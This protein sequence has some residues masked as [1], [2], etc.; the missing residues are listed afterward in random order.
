MSIMKTK[1][2]RYEIEGIEDIVPTLWSH[3]KVGADHQFYKCKEG[4]FVDLHLNDIEDIMLLDVQHKLF[5]LPTTILLTLLWLFTFPEIEFK[6]LYTLSHKPP[7]VIYEDLTKQKRVMR[8]DDLYKFSDETL[9]KVQDELHH[10]IHDF[11]LEYNKEMPRRKWTAIDR[12]MSELMVELI[13][14]QMRERMIIRNL[15]RLV[16]ARELEMDY[17]LM[18]LVSRAKVIENQESVGTPVGR[19]ILFR[20]IPITIPDTTPTVTLLT[21]YVDTTLTPTEIP[22]I[23]PI[24]PPSP[25][26]TPTSLDYSPASDT[27]FDPSEDPSS[28]HIPPLPATLPFISSTDD[29]SDSDTPVTPPSPNYADYLFFSISF[30]TLMI[31]RDFIGDSYLG[32]LLI[33]HLVNHLWDHSHQPD[34]TIGGSRVPLPLMYRYLQTYTWGALSP[35]RVDLLP[36]PKRIRSSDSATDLEDCSDE[37]SESGSDEPYSE[38]DIDPENQVE[39]NEC[40]AYADALRDEGINARVVVKTVAQEEV[41]TSV[42]GPLE[43]RVERV[44][45]PT[46]PDDILEYAQEEEDIEGT[47]ETLGDLSVVL[48]ERISELE[49]DNTRLRGMLDVASQRVSRLQR[50]E[51]RVQALEARDEGRN[52]EPLVEGGVN[53]ETKMVMTMKVEMEEETLMETIMEMVMG[54]EEEMVITLEVLCLLLESEQR[55]PEVPAT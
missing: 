27:E 39:I 8:A 36:P 46:V 31:I 4:D 20:T 37:S 9:T 51:L 54:T 1:A 3:T 13:D 15:K 50:R 42:R 11:C 40:I 6:E 49:R 26:Y 2:A 10:R 22:T 14:K 41:K 53:R 34:T 44:T 33:L 21:T 5:H 16:G 45:H 55:L 52:L 28:D 12:K 19:V 29:S 32:D 38:P 18:T 7:G 25:D 30:Q 17:T 35:A 24:V 47:Y 43:V 48:S 23:S